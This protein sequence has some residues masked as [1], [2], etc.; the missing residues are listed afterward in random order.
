MIEI[1]I[2]WVVFGAHTW[3]YSGPNRRR[4][5]DELVDWLERRRA[6]DGRRML[7]LTYDGA[8][9]AAAWCALPAAGAL[10]LAAVVAPADA[11]G[12]DEWSPAT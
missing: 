12:P 9:T 1:P 8:M 10:E 5:A 3:G 2:V 6:R 7:A 11:P 4:E